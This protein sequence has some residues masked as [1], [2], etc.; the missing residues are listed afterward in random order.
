MKCRGAHTEQTN[1]SR[2]LIDTNITQIT[3]SRLTIKLK[4][5]SV[6]RDKFWLCYDVAL[7]LVHTIGKLTNRRVISTVFHDTH[8]CSCFTISVV[9]E[10]PIVLLDNWQISIN[11]TV[12]I[13]KYQGISLLP[14]Y[15]TFV[16][17]QTGT[18]FH[19]TFI[20]YTQIKKNFVN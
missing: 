3:T 17:N 18:T 5:L 8:V 13:P 14:T 4:R 2:A 20:L 1:C 12:R 9:W 19:R 6:K 10:D 15:C 7:T 16:V 11:R